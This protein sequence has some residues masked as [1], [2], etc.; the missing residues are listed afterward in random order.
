MKNIL[1]TQRQDFESSRKEVRD[2]IDVAW[3]YLLQEIDILPILIPNIF[4]EYKI[5]KNWIIKMKPDGIILSGGNDIG[6]RQLRDKTETLLLDYA[7]EKQLPVFGVCRGMQLMIHRAGGNLIKIDNHVGQRHV[8]NF[9]NTCDREVNSFHKYGYFNIPNDYDI[10]A[11]SRDGS[12]E[13]IIHKKLPW[14]AIMWHPERENPF[15]LKDKNLISD[16]FGI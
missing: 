8:I 14:Q 12:I 7:E 11:K 3:H 4:S 6:E 5:L 2:S 16:C 10:I 1:L 9:T 13:C 15:N